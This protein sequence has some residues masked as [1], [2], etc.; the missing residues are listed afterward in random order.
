[1][2]PTMTKSLPLACAALLAASASPARAENPIY[3]VGSWASYTM[4]MRSEAA[5]GGAETAAAG[6]G[7]GMDPKMLEMLPPDKR[8]QIEA[9]MKQAQ[10]QQQQASMGTM[11]SPA[12]SAD[13]MMKEMDMRMKLSVVG[14]EKREGKD[15]VWLEMA[16]TGKLPDMDKMMASYSS[17]MAG[18]SAEQKAKIQ[19]GMAK[20]KKKMASLPMRTKDG[21]IKVVMKILVEKPDPAKTVAL[22]PIEVWKKQGDHPAVK[23]SADETRKFGRGES[24]RTHKSK[25]HS[26]S[27][28]GMHSETE[29]KANLMG[30]E[31]RAQVEET[32]DKVGQAAKLGKSVAAV[33]PGGQA[34]AMGLG[35]LGELANMAKDVSNVGVDMKVTMDVRAKSEVSSENETHMT[36]NLISQESRVIG[37]ESVDVPSVGSVKT[38]HT[39]ATEVRER[40]QESK[41]KM[42]DVKLDMKTK[43]D[44]QGGVGVQGGAQSTAGKFLGAAGKGLAFVN[45]PFGRKKKRADQASED[46]QKQITDGA[47]NAVNG[48]ETKSEMKTQ[49]TQTKDYWISPALPAMGLAKMEQATESGETETNVTQSGG[50]F[51]D[52]RNPMMGAGMGMGGGMKQPRQPKMTVVTT[53]DQMGMAGAVSEL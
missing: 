30:D 6:M 37:G 35:V 4:T 15:C 27:E 28:F 11:K 12:S 46:M 51:G 36:T 34:A 20:A 5:P 31:A 45:D 25:T 40:I 47:A 53:L 21:R 26:A 19:E 24:E 3:K 16:M 9:Q 44:V 41:S 50:A 8:A 13:D 42:T 18:L 33:I 52:G 48:M 49:E 43:V 1:M 32:A 17:Q 22:N 2:R 38:V 23:L 14:E 7:M 10:Q 29:T 39:Q